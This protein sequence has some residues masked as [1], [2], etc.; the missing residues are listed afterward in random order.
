MAAY[1]LDQMYL[2]SAVYYL[3]NHQWV[4]NPPTSLACDGAGSSFLHRDSLWHLVTATSIV[5]AIATVLR[6][7]RS[8]PSGQG[9]VVSL[10]SA[11]YHHSLVSS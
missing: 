5:R 1:A 2:A 11:T 10:A 7:S 3:L 9:A 4:D 6:T 8:V